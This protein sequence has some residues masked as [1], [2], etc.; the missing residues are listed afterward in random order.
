MTDRTWTLPDERKPLTRKQVA[1]L[2]LRQDGKCPNCGKRLEVKGHRI[3]CV[4]EHLNP[5]WRGG[6]NDLSNRELWCVECTK[7][8]T[9]VEATQRAKCKRT[10]DKHIGVL[11][12]KSCLP[13]GRGSRFKKRIDGNVVD[14]STGEI[15]GRR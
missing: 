13:C 14:R 10:R 3:V 1:S 8:K 7:P 15:V 6:S 4:D 9:S 5:L 12:A 2:Y 11:T